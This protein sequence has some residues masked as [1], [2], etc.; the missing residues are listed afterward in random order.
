MQGFRVGGC[1]T[2]T[3]AHG[4]HREQAQHLGRRP[5]DLVNQA[6]GLT[7]E[8]IALMWGAAPPGVPIA[9]PTA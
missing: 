9:P 7:P 6:Y 3:L 4:R 8:E 5:H 1:E 2:G